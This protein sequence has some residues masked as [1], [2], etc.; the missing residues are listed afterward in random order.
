MKLKLKPIVLKHVINGRSTHPEKKI[1]FT[2]LQKTV[3]YIIKL[4]C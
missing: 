2:E 1:G 4:Q 3:T